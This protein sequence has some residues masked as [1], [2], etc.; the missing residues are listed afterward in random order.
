MTVKR[1]KI[2][3]TDENGEP[4]YLSPWTFEVPQIRELVESWLAGQVL[5]ACAGKSTLDHDGPIHRNDIDPDRDVDTHHDVRELDDHLGHDRFDTVVFDPPYT[6]EMAERHYDGHH[7]GRK[8]EPRGSIANVT[9]P[10]GHVLTFGYNSDGLGG[11]YGWE[12]IATYYFR[13]PNFSGHD[14]C[15]AVDRKGGSAPVAGDVPELFEQTKLV[16]GVGE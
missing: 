11:W 8:L 6:A 14:I 1:I 5:N 13:T 16:A 15:L 4:I 12:R 7:I 9:A 2:G 10:G 3:E